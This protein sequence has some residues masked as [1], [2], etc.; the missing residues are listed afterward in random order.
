MQIEVGY[1]EHPNS[2]L[3]GKNAARE[4]L[5]KSARTDPCDLVL[6]FCTARHDLTAVREEVSRE[7]GNSSSIFGGGAT[8]IITNEHYGYGGDQ[9]G[10]ACVWLD[11]SD[12]FSIC[13][14]GLAGSAK[15]AGA[16]LA[17]K[18]AEKDISKHRPILLFYDSIKRAAGGNT[19]VSATRLLEGME[20]YL[21]Y[22][23]DIKGAGLQGDHIFTPTEMFIGDR[24]D[25]EHAMVLGFSDD[26]AIDSVIVHGCR[27]SSNY[28]TVTGADE[29]AILEIDGVPALDFMDNLLGS[30]LTP[31]EYPFFLILGINHGEANEPYDEK[32]YASRLCQGIDPGRRAIIMF[33]PDMVEGTRF[34]IM[35]RTIQLDYILPSVKG[36]LDSIEDE[37]REPFF[38]LYINCAGRAAGLGG[39][40]LEDALVVQN[41]TKNRFPL[42]GIYT[43]VEIARLGGKPRSLDWT[44]VFCVFSKS[45]KIRRQAHLPSHEKSR[46]TAG[47]TGTEEKKL[48]YERLH[49]LCTQNTAK[50]L[51]LDSESIGL[52]SDLEQKR[53][54]F[55]ILADLSNFFRDMK[56]KEDIFITAT[57]RINAS[58]N[59][60][61]TALLLPYHD[62][63]L[64]PGILQGYSP[65]EDDELLG[66]PIEVEPEFYDP[67]N[68][69]L[70]TGEAEEA[71]LSNVRKVLKLPYLIWVP[72]AVEDDLYGIL[73]TGRDTESPPFL[74]RLNHNDMETVQAIASLLATTI[75]YKKLGQVS[76]LAATD[77]LTGLL[78]RSALER[79]V[80][81]IIK[82]KKPEGTIVFAL[83]D[84]DNFKGINDSY[85]HL[86]GD[87]ALKAL[88]RMLKNTFRSKDVISRFGGDEFAVVCE[89]DENI[90]NLLFRIK[91]LVRKWRETA[92]SPEG[93]KAFHSTLSAGVAISR[94]D[95]T[96][97]TDLIHGADM[98]LYETKEKG[99]DS[100][101]ISYI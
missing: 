58:L 66:L 96:T 40:D 51:G 49:D 98:A 54:G 75:L 90:D 74:S 46:W 93:V 13:E 22:L 43:G 91:D 82:R 5:E 89:A 27:P 20:R 10:V 76:R 63:Q 6:L 78:N 79:R 28:F 64:I 95:S 25:T 30:E 92:L 9:V 15:D 61:R 59:M 87:F 65:E 68:A 47:K 86:V 80:N 101:T 88:A 52:R 2:A 97:F 3:A 100:C 67:H 83:I 34:Q 42:F 55:K 56:N 16:R 29:Q 85:G 45:G 38:A 62:N 24:M 4:A 71:Y 21:D 14:D 11:G 33:E 37:G 7:T 8:G 69:F 1:S 53:R 17:A 57:Q 44:G 70:I 60:Q 41:V 50:I 39:A 26:I 31:E 81:E 99:R 19:L 36:L 32:N 84:L 48:S 94:R 23:P 72:I 12:F 35:H 18:L 73:V 77:P